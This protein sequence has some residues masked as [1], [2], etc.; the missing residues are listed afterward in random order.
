MCI[1]VVK[2][3]MCGFGPEWKNKITLCANTPGGGGGQMD[4]SQQE[5][6]TDNLP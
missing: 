5:K 3:R 1:L 6:L 4:S 2:S